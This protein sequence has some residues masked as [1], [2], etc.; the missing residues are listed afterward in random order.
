MSLPAYSQTTCAAAPTSITAPF[1]TGAKDFYDNFAVPSVIA[2]SRRRL[3]K[4][5]RTSWQRDRSPVCRRGSRRAGS[6]R[7]YRRRVPPR[8]GP[9]SPFPPRRRPN[10][11]TPR[12][13]SFFSQALLLGL[14]ADT[15]CAWAEAVHQLSRAARSNAHAFRVGSTRERGNPDI[16]DRSLFGAAAA[17]SGTSQGGGP[18][19]GDGPMHSGRSPAAG[20]RQVTC[21]A[22]RSVRP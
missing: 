17:R 20:V 4:W 7:R 2:H 15:R 5:C 3:R 18:R 16:P 10:I 13:V 14:S 22:G 21:L 11:A 12:R 1:V 9:A 19:S 6:F 8:S